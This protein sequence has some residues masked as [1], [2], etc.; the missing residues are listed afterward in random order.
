MLARTVLWS[1]LLAFPLH[2]ASAAVDGPNDYLKGIKVISYSIYVEPTIGGDGCSID[3]DNLN[4]SV[5][6]VANQSTN[7]KIVTF[8]Q[9]LR[10]SGELFSRSDA[11]S[12]SSADKE[13][14]KK[15]AHDYNLMPSFVIEIVPLQTQFECAGTIHAKLSAY[16]EKQAHIIPKSC[17]H[18]CADVRSLGNCAWLYKSPANFFHSNYKPHRANYEKAGQRLGGVAVIWCPD[19]RHH[20]TIAATCEC[21]ELDLFGY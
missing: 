3:R 19:A 17:S 6:F 5:Q 14:A 7:L 16:F 13:A 20:S 10:R 21:S 18:H 15:V 12:L 2:S 11:T 1:S 8:D 9:R 4:T